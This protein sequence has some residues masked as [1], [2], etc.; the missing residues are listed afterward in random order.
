MMRADESMDYDKVNVALLQR[1]RQSDERF[2]EN[3][4]SSQLEGSET[5]RQLAA[6]L[7]NYFDQWIDLSGTEKSFSGLREH[8]V[9][10][11][12]L[13]CRNPKLT[14]FLKERKPKSVVGTMELADTFVEAKG[15]RT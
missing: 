10:Q 11:K 15:Q 3:F 5:A 4:R 9:V 12:F 6:R 2:H 8:M 13:D 1:F 14:V 7:A